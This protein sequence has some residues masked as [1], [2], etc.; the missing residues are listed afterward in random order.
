MFFHLKIIYYP[1]LEEKMDNRPIDF[2]ALR[3]TTA[4]KDYDRITSKIKKL[5]DTIK[6]DVE[7]SYEK[8]ETYVYKRAV[9]SYEFNTTCLER[10]EEALQK[11]KDYLRQKY[12]D[13]LL[14]AEQENEKDILK[15]KKGIESATMVMDE[16]KKKKKSKVVIH[17]EYD[18]AELQ[19]QLTK[20]QLPR[21]GDPDPSQI[22][23][24]KI[25]KKPVHVEEVSD[26]PP[27]CPC[28]GKCGVFY[29]YGNKEAF[30][31]CLMSAEDIANANRRKQEDREEAR[32]LREEEEKKERARMIHM[33]NRQIQIDA[34][35]AK[36]NEQRRQELEEREQEKQRAEEERTE[37]EEERRLEEEE[38]QDA[39]RHIAQRKAEQAAAKAANQ[40][41]LTQFNQLPPPD[42]NKGIRKQL[43]TK[44]VKKVGVGKILYNPPVEVQ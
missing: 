5:Q 33:Q 39:Q 38:W 22:L 29:T 15:Y 8:P 27:P 20:L 44:A 9:T 17:A 30:P 1:I 11:R 14:K 41:P 42:A 7:T 28:G 12:E 36:E 13:D 35:I 31:K 18:I 37:E 2:E 40:T 6:K 24:S 21:I 25:V 16:E 3:M 26:K 34:E 4:A 32:A 10:S 23:P 19:K 43:P